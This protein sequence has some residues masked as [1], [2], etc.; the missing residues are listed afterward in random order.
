MSDRTT[1]PS[2]SGRAPRMLAAFATALVLLGTTAI[3]PPALAQDQSTQPAAAQLLTAE[4]LDQLVAPIALYPDNLLGQILTA[5]TYPLEDVMAA[6]WC[7]ANP[8]V[9]GAQLE[10]AMQQEN[11]DPSVKALTAVPQVLAM[12]ND[13]LDW[14]QQLGDAYLAQPDDVAAAVQRLRLKAQAAGNLQSNAQQRVTYVP[15]PEPIVID[16][17][18][19]PNYIAIEPVDPTV[20]YVPVYNPV[21]VYGPWAYPAYVP[22]F[23][24][25]PGFVIG[26]GVI[27][28]SAPFVVGPA[29]WATYDWHSH[30]VDVDVERFNRFNHTTIVA[31]T[32]GNKFVWQHDPS[33]RGNI[34]YN[35]AALQQ[36]FGRGINSNASL[37]PN[38]KGP[39]GN[40]GQKGGNPELRGNT[41]TNINRNN[42]SGP[43]GNQGT[44]RGNSEL[45]GNTLTNINKN[46]N[47]GNPGGNQNKNTNFE[48]LSTGN[49]GGNNGN[50]NVNTN[51]HT[52]EHNIHTEEHH[53]D[54]NQ[55]NRNINNNVI[56]TPTNNNPPPH[57]Q[58]QNFAVQHNN[59]P[60]PP[61]PHIMGGNPGGR[62]GG[63]G[64]GGNQ[65]NQKDKNHH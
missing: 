58:Q 1:N 48:K 24:S 59:P 13:K 18:P 8:G 49:P 62:P 55:G 25:P 37:N 41:L 60:P 64:G 39:L 63:G 40:Q 38:L 46:N 7:Q 52:E 15:A 51:I 44:Q 19:Q 65:N 61:P 20:L 30:H 21:V 54:L 10:S 26:V 34:P 2:P 50:R 14:T 57:I 53:V 56:H 17:V 43:G 27:A 45:R 32:P 33:H 4:Q 22:F 35:N 6:R 16:N 29:I 3:T 47:A 42:L 36:K 23:W 9:K 31:N 12:M 5:S 11:W 28:F